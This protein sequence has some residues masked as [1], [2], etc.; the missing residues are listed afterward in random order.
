MSLNEK[1]QEL[2]TQFRA[3]EYVAY[4][5]AAVNLVAEEEALRLSKVG[6]RAPTFTLSDP[7]SVKCFHS[8]Y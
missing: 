6:E 4:F 2:R 3:N 1:L 8:T 5:D 7:I